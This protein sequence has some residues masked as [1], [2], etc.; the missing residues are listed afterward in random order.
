MSATGQQ[1]RFVSEW[2]DGPAASAR[3]SSLP[4]E[5]ILTLLMG[6]GVEADASTADR[7][8]SAARQR[9]EADR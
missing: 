7:T 1:H 8:E 3:R 5:S 2:V 9:P 6:A 4:A